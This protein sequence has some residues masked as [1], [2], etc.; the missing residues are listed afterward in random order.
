MPWGIDER[1][2]FPESFSTLVKTRLEEKK[3]VYS[4]LPLPLRSELPFAWRFVDTSV[5]LHGPN[6]EWSK[7]TSSGFFLQQSL[8]QNISLF[9]GPFHIKTARIKSVNYYMLTGDILSDEP[10]KMT[11]SRLLDGG[12]TEQWC[13][14]NIFFLEIEVELQE[15]A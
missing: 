3:T 11:V 1:K 14:E 10:L 9:I 6:H 5:H 8:A 12:K 7:Q 4:K 2:D 13:E 15:S